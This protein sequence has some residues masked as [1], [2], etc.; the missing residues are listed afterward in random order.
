M[1]VSY[2]DVQLFFCKK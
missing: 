2:I 1:G